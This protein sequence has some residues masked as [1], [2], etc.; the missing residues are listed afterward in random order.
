[1]S[2]FSSSLSVSR[3]SGSS[4]SEPAIGVDDDKIDSGRPFVEMISDHAIYK[5][6]IN[7][8]ADYEVRLVHGLPYLHWYLLVKM[9]T[10][11]SPYLTLEVTTLD[12]SL[13]HI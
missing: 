5:P 1:M 3:R 4:S 12:L 10:S 9:K 8:E 6:F 2:V 7:V 11:T 13:I